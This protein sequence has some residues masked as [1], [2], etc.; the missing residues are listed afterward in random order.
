MHEGEQAERCSDLSLLA[1][2][3]VSGE[4]SSQNTQ[5]LPCRGWI[6]LLGFPRR[7]VGGIFGELN[8]HSPF[9]RSLD[10]W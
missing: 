10:T 5:L 2:R 7:L 6:S 9:V 1:L 4:K 8:L 3:F